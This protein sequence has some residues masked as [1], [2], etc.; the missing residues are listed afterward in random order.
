MA[1]KKMCTY[2]QL[3]TLFFLSIGSCSDLLAQ[4]H[5]VSG[6]VYDLKGITMPGVNIQIKAGSFGVNTDLNGRYS[7]NVNSNDVLVYSFIG[8]QSQEITI[9]NQSTVD[10]ILT[11]NIQELG[12]VVVTA[13]GISRTTKA[14]QSSIT[15][16]PGVNINEAR[17]NNLGSAIQGR[18]A[19]V[20]VTKAETGPAGSSRVIIRGNK[21]L[22]G[23][24][25]PLYVVD[26]IPMDNTNWGQAGT[27][28]GYDGGDGLTGINPEDI[29][30][31]TV[32]K[33][34]SA[35]A[36]YGSRG[37]YG[38]INISTKRGE[39]R[40]GIGIEFNSTYVFEDVV[41]L[42][43][44]QHTYGSGGLA[45][46]DPDNPDS[47]RVFS[48]PVTQ[49]QAYNWGADS[50]GAK[51]DGTSVVQ[52][53][54]FA[55]PYSCTGDNWNRYYDRGNS[56]TNSISI[57]GGSDKQTF[58]ASFSNMK[59]TAI[60]PNSGFDRINVSLATDGKFGKKVTFNAKVMYSRENALNRTYVSDSPANPVQS[61][62]RIPANININDYL[63]DPDKP[64]A[65]AQG[66]TTP[67]GKPVGAEYQQAN[68]PWGQNP[69]W[70]AYQFKNN[71]LR[72]RIITSGQL[73]YDITGSLYIQGQIG[74]DW[75][76]RKGYDLVPQGTGYLPG[77]ATDHT[78]NTVQEM[79][80]QWILG[81][82]RSFG[83]IRV[84]TFVGGNRMLNQRE[85]NATFGEDFN[86]PYFTAIGNTS[87]Q[88]I[89]YYKEDSGINSLFGSA[90][91]SFNNY[92]YITSTVRNDWFSVLNPENNSKLYPSVGASFVFTDAF[93]NLSK[94]ISFGKL[95]AAWG[96]VATANVY[97]YST[98]PAYRVDGA[99]HLGI[100]MGGY[101]SYANIPNPKLSPALSTELEF[102][103][104]LRFLKGRLGLDFAYYD[105]KTT[106][107]ILMADIS[108]T[109]GF[110][111]TYV[112]IGQL[113]NRGIEILIT[114]I[115]VRGAFKWEV[116][117]NLAKNKNKVV[118]LNNGINELLVEEPRTLT[119]YIKH[120][121][122]YPFGMITGYV[123]K[124]DSNGTPVFTSTGEPVR[125]DSYEILGNGVADVTG[126]FNNSFTYKQFSLGFLIDFK[127]GGDIYSGT[128][129][130][131]TEWGLHKQTLAGRD[132]PLTV[133]GVTQS[134]TDTEGVPVYIPFS[135]TLSE[136][137][138]YHYWN[139]VG[140]YDQSRFIYDASFIKLRQVT[141]GYDLPASILNKTPVKH[142][143]LSFVA[144]NL[145]ILYKNIDNVDPEASYSSSNGQGLDYFGMPSTRSYGFNLRITF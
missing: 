1:L 132:T 36:L 23:S 80:Q 128:N 17:E 139:A 130:R 93:K 127:F 8:Y 94:V 30:S 133:T 103:T 49:Q 140:E 125:S 7:I 37:G 112:N 115:P 98:N 86:I 53:D 62:W 145:A 121:V 27:W 65:V 85:Y 55:R 88:S 10:V 24:N 33:G 142:L 124:K 58:R 82:D 19:G 13:L 104:E 71:S 32:L 52:F 60:I 95:R 111:S 15:K 79:N 134:G 64:G 138:V 92:L 91:L 6:T 67:D 105:Q 2:F 25:Q 120:I 41:N 54:G 21:S 5:V 35:A 9:G 45:N 129:V 50:W 57:S 131:L 22:G 28:G 3:M 123:Q 39:A 47:P 74:L 76:L 69:W 73:R 44:L 81:F 110:A 46:S 75:F 135:K 117:L 143:T 77:G 29:E 101:A 89:G 97:P 107:D 99:G 136:E 96:Q 20:N 63:G 87:I 59:S 4:G 68:N 118:A 144:R 114:A 11:E 48:K 70:C 106:D 40:K 116:S 137:E 16:I 141:L 12:D 34:A 102:G 66:V 31:I 100:P 83:K 61:V 26:G 126:G 43:D 51:L 38:V 14:L 18:V 84:N 56:F 122:G 108:S 42:S 119:V 113:S 72:D 90:E 109:S 78:T